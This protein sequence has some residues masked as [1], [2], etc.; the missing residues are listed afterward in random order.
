MDWENVLWRFKNEPEWAALIVLVI[1]AVSAGGYFYY[2]SITGDGEVEEYFN[3]V[4]VQYVQA[5]QTGDYEQVVQQFQR[6]QGQFPDSNVR[7]K[8][9]FFLGKSYFE[10]GEFREAIQQFLAITRRFPDSFFYNSAH[11]HAGYC[12]Y[13]LGQYQEAANHFQQLTALDRDNP[14]R[15]E[16]LWQ[17]AF[18]MNMAGDSETAVKAL[19]ELLETASDQD[20]YWVQRA[21]ELLSQLAG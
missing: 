10:T 20:S 4:F 2:Q 18:V 9:Y 13:Q 5:S 17:K 7:D 1:V 21:R 8:I 6:L 19:E 12:F 14:I 3:R 11:L 15:L 16:A